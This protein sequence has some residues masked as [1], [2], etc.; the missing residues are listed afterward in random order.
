MALSPERLARD[1]AR[2]TRALGRPAWTAAVPESAGVHGVLELRPRVVGVGRNAEQEVQG[3]ELDVP[4][5]ALGALPRGAVVALRGGAGVVTTY[6]VVG[7]PT[8]VPP[9][10]ALHR[11]QLVPDPAA[12]LPS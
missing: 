12:L 1:A 9:D 6:R 10:G 11:V 2:L 5:G 3:E 8:P 4:A 7:G